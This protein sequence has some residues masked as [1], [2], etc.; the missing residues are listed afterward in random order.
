MN[1]VIHKSTHNNRPLL[2]VFT[3]D[4]KIIDVLCRYALH[5]NCDLRF[6]SLSLLSYVTDIKLLTEFF[7]AAG[8]SSNITH[9]I[10]SLNSLSIQK[11]LLFVKAR[12]S[13]ATLRSTDQRIRHFFNW[14]YSFK[15]GLDVTGFNNP[16]Y[17][18][19]LKTPKP[20]RS[21]R[22]FLTFIEIANFLK[23]FPTEHDRF[24]G[25]F[26]YETGAR[27]SEMSRVRVSDL[28]DPSNYPSD[29]IYYPITIKGSKGRGGN[30]KER[31]ALISRIV[32]NRGWRYFNNLIKPGIDLRAFRNDQI[33]LFFNSR[34]KPIKSKSVCNAYFRKSKQLIEQRKIV[35]PITAHRFR[36]G[37]A[38]SILTSDLGQDMLEKLVIV[39]KH[40][41]HQS[42]KSTEIYAN[43]PVDVL[44]RVRQLN[45]APNI[46]S[47]FEESRYIYDKTF[48][49]ASQ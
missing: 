30:I 31:Q 35:D 15:S 40:L 11:Y 45:H 12:Y 41:G 36:H 14:L 6:S 28:P 7:L 29:F 10:L 37:S 32:V 5:L 2:I 13:D 1:L 20:Y 18:G 23:S 25:H 27:I 3:K 39:K 26:M 16:Y 19:K 49:K 43:V 4:E 42:F 21:G 34:V 48:L 46:L 24:F 22:R 44:Q 47:R 33:P 8:K 38:F 17:D 9:L